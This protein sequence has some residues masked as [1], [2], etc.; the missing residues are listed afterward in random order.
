MKLIVYLFLKNIFRYYNR[1]YFR[2]VK[3]YGKNNIPTDGG[4]IFSPN[5]QGALLDPLVL[6]SLTKGKITSLTRSDIF[7]GPFQ[8]FL[9]AFYM[10]PVY[11]IRNG[12]SNLKKNDEIFTKCY[13]LLGLGK[14]M[15]MYSE[16]GDHNEYYLQNRSK[17][18]SRL[19]FK[20][21][22]QNPGK[23]I[24]LQPVGINYGHHQQPQCT[25]HLVYGQPIEVSDFI[26]LKLNDVEN[27][28]ILKLEL[29]NRMKAC[30][31]LPENT[32][33]YFIQKKK[34]NKHTTQVDFKTLKTALKNNHTKM[35]EVKPKSKT[36]KVL[37]FLLS[38]PNII[39]LWITRKI[40]RKLEDIV[41]GS[42][43]KYGLGVFLFP[44]WWLTTSIAIAYLYENTVMTTYLLVCTLSL[45]IR[46]RISLS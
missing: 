8:W 39:P 44:I 9:D 4:V 16:E 14:F 40:I 23:K 6:A 37:I 2:S 24:Y 15:L 25:L 26:D 33:N 42:S 11:R 5:H 1:I 29:Q 38:I 21:A 31:W 20:A 28:S 10:L 30:L 17:G 13:D 22:Q 32:E 27:I 46:Q 19:A 3:V 12:Y 18:S 7:G 45:F 41:F 36:R 34:I 35:P 43:L